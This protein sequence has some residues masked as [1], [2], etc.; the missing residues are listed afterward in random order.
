MYGNYVSKLF[1]KPKIYDYT[2]RRSSVADYNA[3]NRRYLAL[4]AIKCTNVVHH[5]PQ[6]CARF[7]GKRRGLGHSS[8]L[9]SIAHWGLHSFSKRRKPSLICTLLYHNVSFHCQQEI[10]LL[11]FKNGNAASGTRT[12]DL[13]KSIL[14]TSLFTNFDEF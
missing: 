13:K 7:S 3:R 12:F 8:T 10:L 11:I 4:F 1:K 5:Q 6:C 14:L 9:W 2:L